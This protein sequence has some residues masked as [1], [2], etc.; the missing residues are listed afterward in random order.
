MFYYTHIF[1]SFLIGTYLKHFQKKSRLVQLYKCI[2]LF[3]FYMQNFVY[4]C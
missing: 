1:I 2:Y 4:N 3:I